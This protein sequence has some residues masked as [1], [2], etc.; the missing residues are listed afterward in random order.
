VPAGRDLLRVGAARRCSARAKRD[1]WHLWCPRDGARRRA[2]VASLEPRP[3]APCGGGTA[4]AVPAFAKVR[5]VAIDAAR[6]G[7]RVR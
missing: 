4:R 2:R 5:L 7:R 3:D 1:E 6:R